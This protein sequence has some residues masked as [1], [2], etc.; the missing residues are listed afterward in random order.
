MNSDESAE[1]AQTDG[2]TSQTLSD[3]M[4]IIRRQRHNPFIK[5]GQPDADAY[6]T[7]ACEF[8]AFINHRPK[9]FRHILDRIMIL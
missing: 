3:E 1:N 9:P 7:F 5:D 2:Y 6:I 4:K 8:N